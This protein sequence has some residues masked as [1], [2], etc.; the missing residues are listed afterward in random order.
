MVQLRER[1]VEDQK[2]AMRAKAAER[3]ST[4]RM[5]RSE[6]LNKDKEKGDETSDG[7]VLKLLQSMVKRREEAAEQ[8]DKG[9]RPELAAK[10]REEILVVKEYLPAQMGDEEIRQAAKAVVEEVGASS[11]KDMG[12]VMGVLSKQLAGQATGGRISQIVKEMLST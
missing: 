12:K 10:E 11:P 6:I 2:E 4:I 7:D 1:L 5:I 8:Y 3:L 9:E